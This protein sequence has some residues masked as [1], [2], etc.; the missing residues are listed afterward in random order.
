MPDIYMQ[1]D[2]S[3]APPTPIGALRSFAQKRKQEQGQG[4]V[5]HCELCSEVISSSH[6]HLLNL[7]S[8]VLVCAWP[9]LFITF[10]RAGGRCWQV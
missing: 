6:S 10:Q 8:R 4:Q 3:P 1:D 5:E 2:R 9:G 7:S